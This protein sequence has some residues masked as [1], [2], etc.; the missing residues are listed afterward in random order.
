MLE[1]LA[2]EPTSGSPK[3]ASVAPF[4]PLFWSASVW[5]PPATAS[6]RTAYPIAPGVALTRLTTASPPSEAGL[7]NAPSPGFSVQAVGQ[8]AASCH[9]LPPVHGI[10]AFFT[11]NR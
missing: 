4:C 8:S 11:A 1:Q 9:V 5:A 2:S 10:T 7:T 6:G 3:V